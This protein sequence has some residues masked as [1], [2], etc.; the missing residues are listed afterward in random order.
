MFTCARW[1]SEQER[2][3]TIKTKK[4]NTPIV[5]EK[6]KKRRNYDDEKN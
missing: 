4:E 2:M 1:E 3:K 6:K 5:R